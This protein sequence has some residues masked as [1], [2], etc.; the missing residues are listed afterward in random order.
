MAVANQEGTSM[1]ESSPR[2]P[3]RWSNVAPLLG[4][5][6]VVFVVASIVAG[7]TPSGSAAP[8]KILHFYQTHQH[9]EDA[10]AFL[11]APAVV[12][13]LFW[14]AYL[15]NWL[16]R[17]DVHERWGAVAFVGGVL[18]AVVGGVATGIELALVDTPKN[19]TASTATALNFI[20]ADVPFILA[21]MAFGVMAIATGIAVVKSQYLPTWLGWV[22]L[23]LGIAG[24]LPVGDFLALPAIGVWV[25]LV[26]GVMWFRTD[27]E[28]KLAP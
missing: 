22:S 26:T 20:E 21:S 9:Q 17:R 16:Q 24:V 14:F 7:S 6:F 13:G 11:A 1:T 5:L 18:F 10:S 3:G 27:P 19:L 8:A 25:L 23:V 28:G 12:F 4:V 15:R 2:P